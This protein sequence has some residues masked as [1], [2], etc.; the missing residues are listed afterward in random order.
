MYMYVCMH[1]CMRVCM[2]VFSFHYYY[3][4]TELLI[5]TQNP[6]RASL[7]IKQERPLT[8]LLNLSLSNN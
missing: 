7:L 8:G 3:F 4:V 6:H 5:L 1:A 2:Y